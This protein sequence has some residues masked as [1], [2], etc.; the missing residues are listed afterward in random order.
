MLTIKSAFVRLMTCLNNINPKSPLPVGLDPYLWEHM[1]EFS[2]KAN[3]ILV[4][5]G[6]IPRHAYFII[7]G[8]VR[9][10]YFDEAG[11]KQVKRFY[12]EG[13]IVAFLSFIEQ[14]ESPYYIVAGRNTLLSRIRNVEVQQMYDSWPGMKEFSMLIVLRNE[15]T[16]ERLRQSMICKRGIEKVLG[17]YVAFPE[18]LYGKFVKDEEVANYLLLKKSQLSAIRSYL[19]RDG[20]LP[21]KMKRD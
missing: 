21:Q 12:R 17:F 1:E 20:M 4:E 15:E 5:Q 8:Y 7:R 2:P 14:Q 9:V 11:V 13:R 18:L 10:Y 6:T 19:V 16:K 3:E